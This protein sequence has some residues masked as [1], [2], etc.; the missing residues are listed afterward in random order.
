MRPQK[1]LAL[2]ALATIPIFGFT[3]TRAQT[4]A[5][6]G[7]ALANEVC[8]ECHAVEN[9]NMRSPNPDAPPFQEL[10]NTPGISAM[11][12]RVWLQ[13]PH[14]T[15]PLLVLDEAEI[16]EISEYILSLKPYSP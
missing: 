4:D 1:L 9:G 5:A 3:P 12:I 15:M 8:S 11:T 10:A 14:R 6:P 7:E 13:S 2:V 16:D